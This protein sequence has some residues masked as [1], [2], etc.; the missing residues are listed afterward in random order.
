MATGWLRIYIFIY[1]YIDV[2]PLKAFSSL[3]DKGSK[4]SHFQLILIRILLNSYVHHRLLRSVYFEFDFRYLRSPSTPL[5]CVLFCSL[6]RCTSTRIKIL[7]FTQ[8]FD[9]CHLTQNI[10]NM[11]YIYIYFC[12]R[13]FNRYLYLLRLCLFFA[14][15]YACLEFSTMTHT[16]ARLRG[17]LYAC[18]GIAKPKK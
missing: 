1:I 4:K 6:T 2:I 8:I 15:R 3:T 18:S 9:L 12:S 10:Y 17:L 16:S 14:H 11:R 7:N 5:Q 13:N